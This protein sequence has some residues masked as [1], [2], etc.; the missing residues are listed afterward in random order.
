MAPAL[1]L[2]QCLRNAST[3]PRGART[4]RRRRCHPSRLSR[5]RDTQRRR[6][7]T[8]GQKRS[9]VRTDDKVNDFFQFFLVI[10]FVFVFNRTWHPTSGYLKESSEKYISNGRGTV[11][12]INGNLISPIRILLTI[13]QFSCRL[14]INQGCKSSSFILVN[15]SV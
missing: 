8:R 13:Y 9:I 15:M 6:Q 14:R 11:D 5:P 7:S 2:S 1:C 10:I 3:T 12:T 4:I